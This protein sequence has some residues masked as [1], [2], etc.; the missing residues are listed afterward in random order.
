MIG[1]QRAFEQ[2]VHTKY[3]SSLFECY[4]DLEGQAEVLEALRGAGEGNS[5]YRASVLRQF[6]RY[7][8]KR[9]IEVCEHV[10]EAYALDLVK[11]VGNVYDDTSVV[12]Y[13]I[14][15]ERAVRLREHRNAIIKNGGTGHRTWEAAL[16]LA[17]WLIGESAEARAKA[18]SRQWIEL[19][20]GT[21]L[22]GIVIQMLYPE[23]RVMVTDGDEHVLQR[24]DENLEL[25]HSKCEK[26]RL[27]W[28]VDPIEEVV[29]KACRETVVVAADVTYDEVLIP[30]LVGCIDEALGLDSGTHAIVSATIRS[31][32]TFAVFVY[33]CEKRSISLEV[34][35]CR[36][37]DSPSEVFFYPP[38]SPDIRIVELRRRTPLL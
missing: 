14:D 19:G 34:V 28:G 21:G 11:S 17:E 33:E 9:G 37:S 13:R 3:L 7:L 2:Q 25:N 4:S 29:D 31:D 5:S 18:E 38:E 15:E 23:D 16:A 6:I 35:H 26:C 12:T 24:L 20:A 27:L 8:E 32:A 1:L 30:A 36:S 10:S 22:V